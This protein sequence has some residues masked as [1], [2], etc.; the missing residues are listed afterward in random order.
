MLLTPPERWQRGKSALSCRA[1]S[2]KWMAYSACSSMPVAT[3]RMLVSKMMSAS[4]KPISS[5]RMR[6]AR[7]HTA[8]RSSTVVACFS[9][10][11]AMTMTAAP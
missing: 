4:S 2:M 11:K 1:V 8:T 9:S 5:V 6:W 3:V 10:L 7:R